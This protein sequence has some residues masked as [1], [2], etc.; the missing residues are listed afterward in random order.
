MNF[1]NQIFY[2][3]ILSYLFPIIITKDSSEILK[4]TE[5][6]N[7]EYP[8]IKKMRST[9][10]FFILLNKNIHFYESNLQSGNILRNFTNEQNIE[11]NI[12]NEKTVL[13][14]FNYKNNSYILCLTKGKH[15]FIANE[16]SIIYEN[17]LNITTNNSIGY[18][19][20]LIPYNKNQ[21]LISFISKEI[22]KRN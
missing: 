16:S 21:F 11:S 17:E 1:F 2:L 9:G 19:Y 18:Y 4:Q 5:S 13:S 10:N 20:N 15:L 14:E 6:D 12:D 8:V 7:Y 22:V 3:F